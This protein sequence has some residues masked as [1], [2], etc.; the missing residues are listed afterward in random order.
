MANHCIVFTPIDYVK[1]LLDFI[2][3][4]KK[5]HGKKVLENSCGDGNILLEIVDRYINDCFRNDYNL[6]YIK[7]GL[8]RDII[9]YD[10]ETIHIGECKRRLDELVVNYGLVNVNWNLIN[11]NFLTTYMKNEYSYVIGNPPYITYK[12]INEEERKYLNENYLSCKIGK[13]D[14][15]YAFIEAGLQSMTDD[16]KL[17]YIIPGSIYKNIFAYNLRQLIKHH[18]T[19]VYDYTYETK[20]QKATTSSSILVLEKVCCTNV[21]KYHDMKKEVTRFIDKRHIEV[22]TLN[23]KYSKWQFDVLR[24]ESKLNRFG[25]YYEVRNSIA[26][27]CN[28]AF[29]LN[30]YEETEQGYFVDNILIEKDLVKPAIS[31]R[32]KSKNYK[33]IFPY[34]EI[35]G[36]KILYYS[37]VEFERKFPG[38]YRHLAKFIE[39]LNLRKSDKKA[40]WFEYGRSQGLRSINKRKLVISSII[41][42]KVEGIFADRLEVPYAG[43]YIVSKNSDYKLEDAYEILTSDKFLEYI[44]SR[45]IYSTGKSIR[46]S[47]KDIENYHY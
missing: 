20:F 47:V 13:F 35:L 11:E 18:V 29:I 45:G 33:I 27:L 17:G 7:N 40:K 44:S 41:T 26:T 31:I 1:E 30:K 37:N 23:G 10:I 19:D 5:L 38:G 22:T 12:D 34:K 39:D 46:F 42:G 15:Y 4:T 8:E 2:G 24:N 21:I 25:D 28:K 43:M 9:A 32:S 14:Y 6:D 16:G 36:D 3:Y